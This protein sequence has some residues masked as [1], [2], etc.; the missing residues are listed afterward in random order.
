MRKVETVF[1]QGVGFDPAKLDRLGEGPSRPLVNFFRHPIKGCPT[2]VESPAFVGHGESAFVGHP[3]IRRA[4]LYG[5]P[6]T[7]WSCVVE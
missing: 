4:P 2:A 3:F 6:S 1:K 7:D 5:V